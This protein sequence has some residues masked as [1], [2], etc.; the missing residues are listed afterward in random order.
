[1]T[2]LFPVIDRFEDGV[3]LVTILKADTREVVACYETLSN[4]AAKSARKEI[5]RLEQVAQ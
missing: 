3:A 1:M 2:N 5:K 4:G